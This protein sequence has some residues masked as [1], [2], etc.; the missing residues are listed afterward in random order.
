LFEAFGRLK[1]RPVSLPPPPPE[2]LLVSTAALPKPLQRFR[3]RNAVF[4]R[5]ADAPVVRFPPNGAVLRRGPEGMPLKLSAGVLPLTIL[6]NGAPLLTDLRQREVM[7]PMVGPGFARISVIDAKGR[8]A[9]VQ[10]RIQ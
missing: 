8:A 7:L 4:A 2:T 9:D 5:A 6:V 3:G 10:I 1:A